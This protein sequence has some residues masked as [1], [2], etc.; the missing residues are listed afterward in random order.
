MSRAIAAGNSEKSDQII[1]HTAGSLVIVTTVWP[2]AGSVPEIKPARPSS[3]ATSAPEMA[4]PNF[5]DMVPDE[6]IRLFEKD[7]K[8]DLK[9]MCFGPCQAVYES[10]RR[11]NNVEPTY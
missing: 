8:V 2:V 11:L 6:K 9:R 4:E 5:W 1:R 7:D 10:W 3:K